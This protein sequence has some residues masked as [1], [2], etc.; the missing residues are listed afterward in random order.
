[1]TTIY[2]VAFCLGIAVI[3][4]WSLRNDDQTDFQGQKRDKKF[5]PK[6][7]VEEPDNN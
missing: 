7:S 2:F 1:M 3:I 6:K 4:F 5:A